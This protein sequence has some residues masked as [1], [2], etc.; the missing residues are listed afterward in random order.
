[1]FQRILFLAAI[2]AA[3][4]INI[5]FTRFPC[6]PMTRKL[7]TAFSPMDPYTFPNISNFRYD[8]DFDDTLMKFLFR[9]SFDFFNLTVKGLSHVYCKSLYILEPDNVVQLTLEV[10]D[11]EIYT[12]DA[13]I[14]FDRPSFANPLKTNFSSK[15]RSSALWLFFDINNHTSFPFSLCIRDSPSTTYYVD[16]IEANVGVNPDVARELSDNPVA[17][18]RAIEH[19]LLRFDFNYTTIL[20]DILCKPISSLTTWEYFKNSFMDFVF[21]GY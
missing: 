1:M 12:N 18:G 20:N 16:G 21:S 10:P 9:Y 17:V 6:D 8:S 2:S 7:Q 3:F 14:R 15:L 19:Y 4:A 13:K 5:P 11:L